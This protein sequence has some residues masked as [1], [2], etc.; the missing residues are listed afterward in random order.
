MR[1]LLTLFSLAPALWASLARADAPEAGPW[2]E[3]LDVCEAT[4]TTQSPD[5]LSEFAS[6]NPSFDRDR[7]LQRAVRHPEAPV[8]ASAVSDGSRWFLCTVSADPPRRI[9]NAGRLIG[10]VTGT[11]MARARD[12]DIRTMMPGDD[13]I[14]APMIAICF[15]GELSG[16]LFAYVAEDG[17]GG[18]PEF[19]LAAVDRFQSGAKSPCAD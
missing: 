6:T 9:E 8:V 12:P 13:L 16:V 10:S 4:I 7:M 15:D 11:L 2:L 3:M 5:S 1:L 14:F 17:D 18:E 19:R